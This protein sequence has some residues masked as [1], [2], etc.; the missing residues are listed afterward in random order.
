MALADYFERN[1][2]AASSLLR[3]LDTSLLACRLEQEVIAIVVDASVATSAEGRAVVDLSLRL[4]SRLY[5]T[6]ALVGA[7]GTPAAYLKG[8]RALAKGINPKITLKRS[9]KEA[10]R[11]LAFGATALPETAPC[12]AFTWYVGSDNWIARLSRT[13]PVKS[14]Q[15]SNPLG[16]GAAACLALANVFRAVFAAEVGPESL[17]SEVSMS[18]LNLRPAGPGAANP[19]LGVLSFDDVHLAGSGA[20]GNGFLWAVTRM[21]C[22]GTLH[23]VDPET[24]TDS[25]LQ[26]YAMLMAGD[27]GEQKASLASQWLAENRHLRVVPHAT[28]WAAHVSVLPE[29]KADTVVCAVDSADAR[30]QIQ[31]SLPRLIYNGW[32]QK[33]EAGVSRHQF[34][35]E[36]ACMA[37]L[38]LPKGGGA[39]LDQLVLR[40]LRLPEEDAMLRGVR[41]RMQLN[42]P[43]ERG[44]LELVAAHSGVSLDKLLPFE[45]RPLQE[46][47][48]RGVCGG[49]VMEFQAAAQQARADVPM[50]FQS[51][52]SGILL[53]AELARPTPLEDTITQI[54]LLGSFPERPGRKQRKSLSPVCIC[55]DDDFIEVFK[56]KYPSAAAGAT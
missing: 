4:A 1:A 50:G 8:L 21:P 40:A 39:N 25:N 49:A 37:C 46:L 23:V 9:L 10:T 3:G 26:R 17:D 55:A 53:A 2:Q 15:S 44:F 34:L 56:L 11:A 54:D 36:M 29:H 14:G 22:A 51:T 20:I 38:Y 45:N 41:Q 13:S 5:P 30:V 7:K 42:T 18:L 28:D 19:K 32:T 27:A 12:A 6:I 31:A 35:G 33:G 47:Y 16:A 52:L 24:V 48:V 43:T